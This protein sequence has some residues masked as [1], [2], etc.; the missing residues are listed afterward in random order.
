MRYSG[1]LFFVSEIAK[2]AVFFSKSLIIRFSVF[3]TSFNKFV[4]KSV[5][6]LEKFYKKQHCY[7]FSYS[8]TVYHSTLS[9]ALSC[10]LRLPSFAGRF[11][12]MFAYGEV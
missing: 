12:D 11:R 6:I 9:L 10:F 4:V 8:A 7:S 1:S 2:S 5:T 3:L